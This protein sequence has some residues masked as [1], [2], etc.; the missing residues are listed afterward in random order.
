M[1]HTLSNMNI[2]V[3][4]DIIR[5]RSALSS[6]ARSRNSLVFSSTSSTLYHEHIELNNKL[7]ENKSQEPIDSSQLSYAGQVDVSL[8]ER[9]LTT[10]PQ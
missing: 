1:S 10:L 9:Q 8:S 3:D 4:Y 6:K 5:E 7:L 2:D